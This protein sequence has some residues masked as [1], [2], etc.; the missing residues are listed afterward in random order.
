[1]N[2]NNILIFASIILTLSG[3]AKQDFPED[4]MFSPWRIGA[5]IP[6]GYVS[7]VIEA[8]GVNYTK[9]WTSLMLPYGNLGSE[10]RL[11][12]QNARENLNAE[13]DGYGLPLTFFTNFTPKQIGFGIKTLPE[14]L[15][16]IWYSLYDTTKYATVIPVTPEIKAAMLKPYTHHS[17]R[18]KGRNC[19][20]TNFIFGLLPHGKVKLWLEGC[21]RYTYIGE[22]E[23]TRSMPDQ[24]NPFGS[25]EHN[26]TYKLAKKEGLTIDPIPWN[27]V[28][29]VWYNKEVD[30]M[31]TLEEALESV[32]SQTTKSG[33]N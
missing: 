17:E 16:M 14:E 2:K 12:L 5:A 25:N 9:D 6:Y 19:Y 18:L 22:F 28:N 1:M 11:N 26:P 32:I 4:D 27:K 3:C 29:K 8:Y 21:R 31:Q 30:T 15:Y 7:T 13:Y 10:S 33:D 20:Q 23:P 24:V